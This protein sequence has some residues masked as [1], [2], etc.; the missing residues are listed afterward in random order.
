MKMTLVWTTALTIGCLSCGRSF[1][2]TL[3]NCPEPG[4]PCPSDDCPSHDSDGKDGLALAIKAAEEHGKNSEPD[5][6]VGDLQDL[7]MEM[8]ELLNPTQKALFMG[9]EQVRDLIRSELD[10]DFLAPEGE[11]LREVKD[12]FLVIQE[13]GSSSELYVHSLESEDA[14]NAYR[15]RCRDDGSYLTSQPIQVSGLLAAQEGFLDLI[16]T[17]VKDGVD[18]DFPD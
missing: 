17:I 12:V 9:R 11:T 3:D 2:A 4:S 14:A 7:L 8:W 13:G 10:A 15:A 18:V 1:D 5:H 16:S 6:E